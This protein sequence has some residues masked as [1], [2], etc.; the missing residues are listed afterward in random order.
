LFRNAAFVSKHKSMLWNKRGT[1][2]ENKKHLIS[3][4]RR[5]INLW[6]SVQLLCHMPPASWNQPQ[7]DLLSSSALSC[8]EVTA[9]LIGCSWTFAG[10]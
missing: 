5:S 4:E 1:R 6:S 9:F 7:K 10:P 2:T 8:S 3:W